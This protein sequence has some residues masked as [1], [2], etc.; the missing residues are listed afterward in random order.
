MADWYQ[1]AAGV[2]EELIRPRPPARTIEDLQEQLEVVK[3]RSESLADN[4]AS[5]KAMDRSLRQQY[6]V[7]PALQ[8]DVIQQFARSK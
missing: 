6:N 5:L 2:Y 8:D 4:I 3:K 1:D 7:Q